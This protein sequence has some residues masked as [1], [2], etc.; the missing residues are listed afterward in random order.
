[1]QVLGELIQPGSR[2]LVAAGGRGGAG[3]RA[4]S[5]MQRISDTRREL[6]AARVRQP[7]SRQLAAVDL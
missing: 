3:V 7:T 6:K 4:P 2:L 1:M 5:H